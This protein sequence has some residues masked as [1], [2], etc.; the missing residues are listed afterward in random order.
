MTV[1]SDVRAPA[2]ARPS[3]PTYSPEEGAHRR[4]TDRSAWARRAFLAVLALVVLAGA[5]GVFGIKTR[6]VHATSADGSVHVSVH[7]PQVARAGDAVPFRIA[8]TRSAG[9]DGTQAIRVSSSYL[10]LFDQNAVT[11]QPE[12]STTDR[13]AVV[14]R[15]SPPRGDTLTVSVDMAVQSNRHWGRDGWVEVLGHGGRVLARATFHTWL[16]P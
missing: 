9:F 2:T 3:Q 1:T 5:L 14:W 13:D 15:F 16:A 4:S 11:P 12:S 7:Y 10:E 6:T 8:V